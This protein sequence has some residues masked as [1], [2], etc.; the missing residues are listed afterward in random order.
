MG[1]Y[2]RLRIIKT[3]YAAS[4]QALILATDGKTAVPTAHLYFCLR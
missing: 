1:I 4:Y 3:T 2:T